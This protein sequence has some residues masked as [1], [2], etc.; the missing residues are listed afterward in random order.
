MLKCRPAPELRI[1]HAFVRWSPTPTPFLDCH[2]QVL[3]GHPVL[4]EPFSDLWIGVVLKESPGG[5]SK[6]PKGPGGTGGHWQQ[7]SDIV[8]RFVRFHKMGVNTGRIQ[9]E[10]HLP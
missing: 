3:W 5:S 4:D 8:Q 1:V 9:D 7:S 2:P 10:N 6:C